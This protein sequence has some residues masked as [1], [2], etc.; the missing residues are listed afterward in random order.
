MIRKQRNNR[1]ALKIYLGLRSNEIITNIVFNC[2]PHGVFL[3]KGDRCRKF[4]EYLFCVM[5]GFVL[6]LKRISLILN[7]LSRCSRKDAISDFELNQFFYGNYREIYHMIR[8]N[9]K[10]LVLFY[11]KQCFNVM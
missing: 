9:N 3:L 2:S 4:Y 1:R 8:G 6:R 7:I 11:Q 10:K 5:N